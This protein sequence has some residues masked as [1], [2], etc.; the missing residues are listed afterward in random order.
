VSRDKVKRG[1][2]RSAKPLS[3]RKYAAL[4][5]FRYELRCFLYFSESVA[6]R[7]G[8][9][10]QQHQALLSV[11]GSEAGAQ[12]IKELAEALLI[13]HHS[14]SGLASRLVKQGLL[15]KA[16]TD[17]RRIVCLRLTVRAETLLASLSR[18][19][20]DELRRVKPLLT[21]LIDRIA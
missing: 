5:R 1:R 4:A 15:E 11:R 9:T 3:N 17:D 10:P 19:H 14:A 6:A 16:Q 12:T 21:K 7:E 20:Q 13:R 8:L 2:A 18:A